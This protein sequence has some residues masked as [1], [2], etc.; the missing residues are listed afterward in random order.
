MQLSE[1]LIVRDT[2]MSGRNHFRVIEA[3]DAEIGPWVLE[4]VAGGSTRRVDLVQAE[5]FEPVT[6]AISVADGF[7]G[8]IGRK[9]KLHMKFGTHLTGVVEA[10]NYSEFVV[11][12]T[13]HRV[14][15]EFV[16]VGEVFPVAEV[17]RVELV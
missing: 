11:A 3:V 1:G 2:Q 10:V 14:P 8:L 4:K 16:L 5:S 12:Q 15:F 17:E 6:R 9:V 7:E 13:K